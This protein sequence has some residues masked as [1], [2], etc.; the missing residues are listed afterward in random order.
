MNKLIEVAAGISN[1]WSLAAFVVAA[2]L[3]AVPK[4]QGKK[5]RPFAWMVIIAL[6]FVVTVPTVAS[7][8]L[9]KTRILDR[10]RAIYHVRTIVLDHTETPVDAAKVW[11]SASGEA[12][13]IAGGWQ[14]DIP[15]GSKPADGK[16]TVYA[17][18]ENAFLTGKSEVQLG[19]DRILPSPYACV[20]IPPRA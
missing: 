12:K 20:Q 10:N 17:S 14:F 16:L 1:Q 4:M 19:E 5:V 13:K 15:E 7:M 6:V 18:V 9:E 11:S 3:I 2:I 8:Y